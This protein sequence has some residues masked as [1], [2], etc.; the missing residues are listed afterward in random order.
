M[1]ALLGRI[2]F[3]D[4][5]IKTAEFESALATLAHFGADGTGRILGTHHALGYHELTIDKRAERGSQ[6]YCCGGLV[7][8]AD[9]ILDNR[10]ELADTLG[11]CGSDRPL[12]DCALI[13]E[14]YRKW[15]SDCLAHLFG[16]FAFA[17]HDTE[18]RRTFLARDH[19]GTRPLYW[20]HQDQTLIF[21]T[22]IR[23]IVAFDD[24]EW[25]IDETTV[26]QYLL[27]PNLPIVDGF[28]KG[29]KTL[30]P[31]SHVLVAEKYAYPSRWW[32]P[33]QAPDIRFRK[34]EDYVQNFRALLDQSVRDRVQTDYPVGSHL[35]GGID[36]SSVTVLA[37]DFLKDAGR[38]LTAAY[39]WSPPLSDAYPDMGTRDERRAIE[40]IA[41]DGGYP[42]RYTQAAGR[43]FFNFLSR[44]IEF[45]GVAD[46]Y[47]EPSIIDQASNDGVRVML[48]GWGGD[49]A[50]SALGFGQ[51]A[52]QLRRGRLVGAMKTAIAYSGGSRRPRK[53]LPTFWHHGIVPNLP[54][55]L[56]K[57]LS[58]YAAWEYLAG[59]PNA[60][61]VDRVSRQH[62]HPTPT[63]RMGPDPHR[64]LCDLL[65]WG[66]LGA[67]ADA[68]TAW[69][70]R[71]R[72]QYRYP[73]L[74][75]RLI[76]FSVGLPPDLLHHDGKI[77][78]V[79]R[80]AMGDAFP[81]P[82]NKSD[83]ANAAL[84]FGNFAECWGI[85]S[86]L[87]K[88][89]EFA[90]SCDWIDIKTF[91]AAI[92]DQPEIVTSSEVPTFSQI[93]TAATIWKLWKRMH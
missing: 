29:V 30:E 5:P 56:Y 78:Y 51:L 17:I 87:A 15:G 19:I 74:E 90:E 67:R 73:L 18:R 71:S 35:S 59:F 41:R 22:D 6:P 65:L 26:A 82:L 79:P 46:L 76:E 2:E 53:L 16:D 39:S 9:A 8:L 42:V 85:L 37:S 12:P 11:L 40:Q 10:T 50:F 70:A 38:N 43:D 89:G 27:L 88:Q 84:R 44:K 69:A 77:R 7:I 68:W 45:D 86:I 64:Y 47:E 52:G 3:S 62:A 80:A 1:S 92:G 72:L 83:K 61:L 49:E 28:F 4:R 63:F 57:R 58:P 21:A 23:G 75:R 66:H 24:F 54:G 33:A 31:G 91:V 81:M 14:A 25:S 36:S 20:F 93:A 32:D 13:L 55:T 48:S 34:T 60:D